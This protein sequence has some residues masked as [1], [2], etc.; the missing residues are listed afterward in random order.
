[1]G[2]RVEGKEAL[3]NTGRFDLL[4]GGTPDEVPHMFELACPTTH[5]HPSS[6]PTLLLHGEKDFLVPVEGTL[7]HHAKLVELGVP[8]VKVTFP[9]TDHIFDL[10]FPQFS[11]AAQSALYHVDRFLALLAN[12]E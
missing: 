4:L 9:W 12:K 5:I 8:A 11:P 1:M 3:R 10:L 7:Q 6:P 2:T